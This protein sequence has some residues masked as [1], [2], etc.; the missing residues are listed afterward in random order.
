MADGSTVNFATEMI[1]QSWTDAAF[2]ADFTCGGTRDLF[3]NWGSS[4]NSSS[5][6]SQARAAGPP[7]A[8]PGSSEG[9]TPSMNRGADHADRKRIA[10]LPTW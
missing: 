4:V 1:Q 6:D 5:S 8:A 2:A 7:A 9:A 10:S 3:A